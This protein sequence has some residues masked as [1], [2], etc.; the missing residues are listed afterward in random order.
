MSAMSPDA[1][2]RHRDRAA[3]KVVTKI[4]EMVRN[5]RRRT[6]KM[7][8]TPLSRNFMHHPQLNNP[9]LAP[10]D[11]MAQF[12]FVPS[13]HHARQVRDTHHIAR[14]NTGTASHRARSSSHA[15]HAHQ[16]Q[17]R[18]GHEEHGHVSHPPLAR[19]DSDRSDSVVSVN[20]D[21]HI[22]QANTR[23]PEA[24]NHMEVA[25]ADVDERIVKF[26]RSHSLLM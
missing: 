11:S 3:T 10:S 2:W 16:L 17:P 20:S 6:T 26:M 13:H 19:I 4:K 8:S 22:V 5:Q 21:V 1:E 7:L 14:V 25:E 12:H 15:P 23:Y 18:H 9:E 24:M